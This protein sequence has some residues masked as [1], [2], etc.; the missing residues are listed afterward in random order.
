[1]QT[2]SF[3]IT[4][5]PV[6]V[7]DYPM[8]ARWMQSAHWQEWWGEPETELQYVMDMLEGRDTTLPYIFETDG[9]PAGYIQCWFIGDHQNE[10]WLADNPWLKELPKDAVGVDLSIG[11][12]ANIAKGLGSTVLRTFAE[13]LHAQGYR[14]I[15]IDP[16]PRNRRAVRAYRKA[17]FRPIPHLEGCVKDVLLMHY[18]RNEKLI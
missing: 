13:D 15:I 18:D 4:F 7:D 6:T 5:R 16:D 14:Y 12:E 9:K 10:T 11:E 3:C 1:M 17:G 8:L 2:D